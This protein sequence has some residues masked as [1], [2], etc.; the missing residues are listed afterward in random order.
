[1]RGKNC[2][3]EQELLNFPLLSAEKS[4]K[5]SKLTL[6][7]FSL[8]LVA[9]QVEKKSGG[10]D[11]ISDHR[12]ATNNFTIKNTQTGTFKEPQTLT[13]TLSFPSDV[14][15]TGNPQ[16]DIEI[17]STTRKAIYQSGDGTKSLTFT[18]D[19]V[20]AD[21]DV[22]GI[23]FK[24]I[25][26]NGATLQFMLNEVLTNCST[27][28]K[29]VHYKSLRIDNTPPTIMSITH[30]HPPGTYYW[31]DKLNFSV[32]FSEKI[33]VTGVPELDL[34]FTTGG[35]QK[36]L[37]V[38]GSGSDTLTFRYNIADTVAATGI[39]FPAG[40]TLNAATIKDLNGFDLDNT[41]SAAIRTAA[42]VSTTPLVVEGR[43]PKL[44][45]VVLPPNGTYG[46]AQELDF[47]LVFD[48]D[49]NIFGNPRLELTVGSTTRHANFQAGDG[50]SELTFRYIPI[51]GD[52]DSNGITLTNSVIFPTPAA[53]YIS[54]TAGVAAQYRFAY[55]AANNNLKNPVT[56]GIRVAAIQPRI[57]NITRTNDST[58]SPRTSAIDNVWNIGQELF[59]Q[60]QFNTPIFV[61]NDNGSP[62]LEF[63]IGGVSKTA[64]YLSGGDGQTTLIFRYTVVEGDDSNGADI[65]VGTFHLNN[66]VI[67]DARETQ[68]Q[69]TITQTSVLQTVIDGVRP[70]ISAVQAPADGTYSTVASLTVLNFPVQFSEPVV[71]TAIN[72]SDLPITIGATTRNARST[73]LLSS[74]AA[75]RFLTFRYTIAG[76]DNDNDGI[77]ITSP[78][79]NAANV[80]DNA[81]NT[82]ADLTYTAPNLTNVLVDTTRPIIT[83]VDE[84]AATTYVGGQTLTFTVNFSEPVTYTGSPRIQLDIGGT[85]QNATIVTPASPAVAALTFSYTPIG[86]NLQDT[87]ISFRA[88]EAATRSAI[89]DLGRNNIGTVN[90]PPMVN[91]IGVDSRAPTMTP[92]LIS[93]AGYYEV[94]EVIQVRLTANENVT[95]TG[96]PILRSN[97]GGT[98]VDFEYQPTGSNGTQ[99]IFEYTVTA[100]DFDFDGLGSIS[101]LTNPNDIEDD[102]GNSPVAALA[103]TL[104]MSGIKVKPPSF[105]AWSAGQH[106]DVYTGAVSFSGAT[107]TTCSGVNC[108][109]LSN[110]SL[111]TSVAGADSVYARLSVNI[112]SVNE[113]LFDTFVIEDNGGIVLNGP[114]VGTI[115]VNGGAINRVSG[116]YNLGVNFGT[117]FRIEV[118]LPSSM[119]EVTSAN[120]TGQFRH[121]FLFN[122]PLTATER[123]AVQTAAN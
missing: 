118:N 51:P 17:G 40:I 41:I 14:I 112:S 11:Y 16:L 56:T 106:T 117:F 21:N 54:S 9:C 18:Y 83:S 123:S 75:N 33:A 73:A 53:D 32:K 74:G 82:A 87:E 39:T 99:L 93:S 27:S 55:I 100:S 90:L 36:A 42:N 58:A 5:M 115:L 62:T 6:L 109:S 98:N 107:Q 7:L 43:I 79:T 10:D 122:A 67:E 86:T 81:G 23:K 104:T 12:K 84:P 3:F 70:V 110:A 114:N 38:S 80:R 8:F 111:S 95:V 35:L 19:I 96:S 50:T 31:N 22:D 89:Q 105:L 120:F 71:L 13:F 97:L 59:L 113:T 69:V 66:S 46:A 119:S 121:L 91:I 101:T 72:A 102:F 65:G 68:A 15:V 30:A 47:T 88:L 64:T 108:L 25:D 26:L 2:L 116:K 49:V 94:G 78:I 63:T 29:E 24:G 37:Y 92:S 52:E 57:T 103:S 20:N 4:L 34:N 85:T 60:V 61:N 76:T 1:M 48:R 77:T 28:I 45:S 44:V